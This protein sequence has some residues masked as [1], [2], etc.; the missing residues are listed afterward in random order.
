MAEPTSICYGS[1]CWRRDR[2]RASPKVRVNHF[3]ID[4]YTLYRETYNSALED[5]YVSLFLYTWYTLP[6]ESEYLHQTGGLR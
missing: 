5:F 3:S 6:H 1:G 2:R 4:K